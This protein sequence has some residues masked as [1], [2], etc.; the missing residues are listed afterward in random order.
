MVRSSLKEVRELSRYAGLP[1]YDKPAY[2]CLA[3][4]IL[5][6]TDITEEKLSHVDRTEEFIRDSGVSWQVC[7]RHHGNIA[8]IKLPSEKISRLLDDNLH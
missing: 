4:Q 8:R 6:G 2:V 1:I 5:Y 7:V 3:S